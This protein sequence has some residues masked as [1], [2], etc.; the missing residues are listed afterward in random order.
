MADPQVD[1]KDAVVKLIQDVP[2]YSDRNE[3]NKVDKRYKNIVERLASALI[4]IDKQLI[5]VER[6]EEIY[7]QSRSELDALKETQKRKTAKDITL[8][9][10]QELMNNHSHQLMVE[11]LTF[12]VDRLNRGLIT[13]ETLA[14]ILTRA[15]REY[16]RTLDNI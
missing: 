14:Q 8:D 4:Q 13:D 10:V 7:Q 12:E 15:K 2:Y 5:S 9:F 16:V 6:L 1:V 11:R 3:L